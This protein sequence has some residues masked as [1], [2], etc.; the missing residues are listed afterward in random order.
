M[1]LISIVVPVYHNAPSLADLLDELRAVAA[2]NPGDDFE[3]IFIDDGSRDDSF[4]VLKALAAREPRMKA[5]KLS[6]NF[7]S[8]PAIMAGLSLARGDAV[9]AIAADL[10]DP[11]ALLHDMIA[12]WRGERKVVIAAR[13][14][15]ADPFPTSLLSDTFYR[16]FQRFAIKSMPARGFDFFLIDKQVCALI[17]SIQENNAYLMGLILWLGFEPDII[18]YDREARPE[19][20]GQSMWTLGRKMKYFVDSFVAF[21]HFPIRI[22]SGL[23]V[24]FS[25]LGLIYAIWV[26][27]A[28]L[29]L[30]I[31]TEG[32]ASLIVVVLI[33]AGVQMLI[34]GIIGEY[35]WRNLDETRRRPR[36]I[37]E[38]ILEHEASAGEKATDEEAAEAQ[39]TVSVKRTKI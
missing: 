17:N 4:A 32:W 14:G 34:L 7:G 29:A 27:Y 6:R 23:G 30:G 37:I 35:M 19:R 8:N 3:F 38:R 11:P 10:Q 21:S 13:R 28:R 18:H 26:I 25:L 12:R 9:A 5:A 2:R 33:A 36:F 22:S 31:Q 16:L 39:R 20:Y 1:S 15:R 24:L